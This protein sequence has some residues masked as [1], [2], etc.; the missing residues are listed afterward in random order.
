M[1]GS[2][3]KATN[4]GGSLRQAEVFQDSYFCY[5]KSRNRSSQFYFNKNCT[6]TLARSIWQDKHT[7]R[8]TNVEFS[9]HHTFSQGHK[10]LI[11]LLLTRAKNFPTSQTILVRGK[12]HLPRGIS[13]HSGRAWDRDKWEAVRSLSDKTQHIESM[14]VSTGCQETYFTL[15]KLPKFWTKRQT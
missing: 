5:Q 15:L 3:K 12:S 13:L 14:I 11:H 8:Q 4:N 6:N 2:F 1:Y 7:E 9:E 10:T